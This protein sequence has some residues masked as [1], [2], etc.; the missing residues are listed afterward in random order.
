M[1]G[2]M[3]TLGLAASLTALVAGGAAL[4]PP[5]PPAVVRVP[6]EPGTIVL[7]DREPTIQAVAA[8][9]DGDGA[10]ELVRLMGGR[11]GP[12]Y[13]EAYRETDGSWASAAS[14][15]TA[16]PGA[17]GL[18]EAAYARRPARL[19]LR[20]VAGRDRVTL[21]VQPSFSEPEDE[22]ECCLLIH[23]LVLDDEAL[24]IEQVADPSD[25]ADAVHVI[26]LDGDGTD[27][28]LASYF[29]APLNDASSLT[30][31]RVF[32]WADDHFAT[33][34]A[35]RL[36]VGS[37]STP[38]ILGDSDGLPGDE[39]AFISS[40]ALN[41]LFRISLGPGDT[42]I[43]EDSGLIVDDALAVPL[44]RT[45]RGVAVLTPRYGLGTLSW[46]RGKPPGVPIAV[47]P[48]EN[49]RL[50]GVVDIGA[51][52][53]LLVHRTT[54]DE[55]HIRALP[56]LASTLPRGPIAPS[57]AA[58]ML[59]NGPLNP[60]VGPLPGGGR[61]G[62]FAAIVAGRLVPAQVLD[63][64]AAAIGALA[65][66]WPVGLVGHDR[67]W[68]AIQQGTIGVPPLDPAGGRL[69]P[70]VVQ[71]ASAVAIAPLVVAT[72]PEG[73]GGE[74]DPAIQGG[75]ELADGA[76]GVDR[77]GFVADVVAPP[78]SRVYLPFR[79]DPESHGV[80]VV[81]SDG[82]MEVTIQVPVGVTA[83]AD[84]TV[85]MTVV[86]PAGHAYTSSWTL[87]LVNGPPDIRASA[88]T[89]L[90]STEVIVAGRAP[91]YADVEVAGKAVVL[92][93]Q[94]RFSTSVDLPPWPS[95]VTI[96]ARDPIGHHASIVVSGV[97]IFDYR[98]LPWLPIALVILGGIAVALFVRVPQ[99]RSAS[100]PSA[101][102]GALEEIDPADGA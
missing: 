24:R 38:V 21:V 84:G 58:A 32:R 64:P 45:R 91:P 88:Q 42:L 100:R 14:R 52:P 99:P 1:L 48:I 49:A 40:S 75:V 71:L 83:G 39:A 9:L 95:A 67:A 34:T 94:G 30:E 29:L 6:D 11:S 82:A 4:P 85:A 96:T 2:P 5:A 97:G 68:L 16:V 20:Q 17:A 78:G 36:P 23:D 98:G 57:Q 81:G 31:A 26:D 54:P 8:D 27:E 13:V 102:D 46:P 62:A 72:S 12:L 65:A 59:G 70:P 90:G 47:Q 76:I 53:R 56:D 10:P 3:L 86:T 33:P 25:V 15:I 51:S 50:V 101:D 28:L 89:T 43:T 44:S 69:D 18:G 93:D 35:T 61:N 19:L 87:R 22:R 55:L 73:N 66:G 92:D 63:D 41:A 79:D 80:L 74:Y 37:G 60:Y 7:P 77:A